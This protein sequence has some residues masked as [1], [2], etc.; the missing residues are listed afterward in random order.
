MICAKHDI[1]MFLNSRTRFGRPAGRQWRCHKCK[2]EGSVDKNVWGGR[3]GTTRNGLGFTNEDRL[4][5]LT[6]NNGQCA[7]CMSPATEAD[8]VIPLSLGG[9]SDL[10][11]GAPACHDCNMS[12]GKKLLEDWLVPMAVTHPPL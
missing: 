7:Y 12:K 2:A 8:H 4:T 6:L 3:N 9:S 5:I 11:N 10:R 1:P